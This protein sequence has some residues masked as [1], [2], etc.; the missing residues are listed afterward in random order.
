MFPW[1]GKRE[2][3]PELSPQQSEPVFVYCTRTHLTRSSHVPLDWRTRT[4]T[5]ME[6]TTI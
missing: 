6:A 2:P 1:I 5:G 4:R 3:E